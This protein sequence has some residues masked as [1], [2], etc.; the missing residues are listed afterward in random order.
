MKLLITIIAW[1]FFVSCSAASTETEKLLKRL[2]E[3]LEKREQQDMMKQQRIT[4]LT[5]YLEKV[6]GSQNKLQVFESLFEEYEVYQ[7]DSAL[8]YIDKAI[9]CAK[10]GGGGKNLNCYLIRKASLLSTVGFYGE[11][12]T[13]LDSIKYLNNHIDKFYYYFT[14]FRYYSNLSDYYSND[15]FSPQFRDRAKQYFVKARQYLSTD[16]PGHDY[17]LGEYYIYVEPNDK[18]ALHYYFNTLKTE[19]EDSRFYA[20]AAFAIAN[21]YSA[22]GNKDLYAYYLTK[23]AISDVLSNTR[24]NLALQELAIYLMEQGSEQIYRAENYIQISLKDARFCNSLLRV[25]EIS[26]KLPTI[27]G[28]YENNIR[29]SNRWLRLSLVLVTLL[30]FVSIAFLIYILRQNGRLKDNREK[31]Y[32][33]N[34]QLTVLN[35]R[36]E[37]LNEALIGTNHKR[38]TLVKLYIDLC[39]KFIGRLNRYKSL[40]ERKIKAHQTDDLLRSISS[41]KLSVEDAETFTNRFD[42]CFLELYPNFLQELN[43]LLVKPFPISKSKISMLPEQRVYALIR[44]GVTESSEIAAVLFYSPQT[45]YNYRSAVKARAKNKDTLEKD[46]QNLNAIIE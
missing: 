17:Y 20:M 7:F 39:A 1:L 2:D 41:T 46:V 4:A 36:L 22:H 16:I 32:S 37:E 8:V 26:Q 43:E 27:V 9:E 10:D 24:E 30:I 33:S 40:V 14:Y 5:D 44:L 34:S 23:A 35:S 3:V 25:I 12:Q 15:K 28:A 19:P 42:K 29:S 21:N 6:K 31:L 18:R 13:L 45:V 38:E 11:A